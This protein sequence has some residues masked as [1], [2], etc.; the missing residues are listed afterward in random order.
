MDKGI[1]VGGT[2]SVISSSE[3]AEGLVLEEESLPA[4]ELTFIS[5]D[6]WFDSVDELLCTED[7]SVDEELDSDD[8]LLCKEDVKPLLVDVAIAFLNFEFKSATSS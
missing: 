3:P 7:D 2:A 8:G 1:T 5:P 4:T 6:D